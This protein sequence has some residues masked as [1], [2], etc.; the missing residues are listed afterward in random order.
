MCAVKFSTHHTYANKPVLDDYCTK[1]LQSGSLNCLLRCDPT[2]SY[3][4]ID[5]V[6]VSSM[7][8]GASNR[9]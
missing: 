4:V 5:N 6:L 2:L 9:A 3:D 1:K 7:R 8:L